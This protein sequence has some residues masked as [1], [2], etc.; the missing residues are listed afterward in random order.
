MTSIKDVHQ[1]LH[2]LA[3]QSKRVEEELERQI[4]DADRRTI[5]SRYALLK[6]GK[7]VS[8]IAD[9]AKVLERRLQVT[10]TTAERISESV[11]QLDEEIDRIER[12]SL[13]TSR[14]SDLRASLQSLSTAIAQQ[15]YVTATQHCV[16][17]LAI[18]TD[19]VHSEFA[20]LMVPSSE[21]PEPPPAVLLELR[22]KLLHIYTEKFEE[23]TAAKDTQ[24]ATKYFT[25]LPQIGWPQE[26]LQV[27]ANFARGM[28]RDKGQVITEGL[29]TGRGS[30]SLH[31]AA[32]LTYLF[33]NLASLIDQHQ[34]LVDLHY[35]AGSFFHGV[36]P[37][38]QQECDRL[39]KRICDTWFDERYVRRKV[40][41]A[42]AYEFTYVAGIGSAKR[43]Q[44]GTITAAGQRLASG[45]HVPGRPST[46]SITNNDEAGQVDTR[47]V[48]KIIGEL[49]AMASRWATYKRFLVIRLGDENDPSQSKIRAADN[50]EDEVKDYRKGSID[51]R[52][53]SVLLSQ[54]QSRIDGR[55]D[56]N[57]E[58]AGV[59]FS[60]ASILGKRVDE[61][62]NT[63]YIPL[64]CWFL[65][66]SLEKA[67]RMDTADLSVRPL[68]SSLL[69]DVFYLVRLV[70]AR[71][72]STCDL[73][74]LSTMC[75]NVRYIIDEDFMQPIIRTLDSTSR[76]SSVSMSVEGPRKDAASRELRQTFGVYLNVLSTSAEYMTRILNEVSSEQSLKQQFV[77]SEVDV[78]AST[79]Q[80]LSTIV[81][82]VRNAARTHMDLFF[83][84]LLRP[85]LRQLTSESLR[86]VNYVL[87]EQ[88]F[89]QAE[90]E[91]AS[92]GGSSLFVRRLLRGWETV[93]DGIG[94][95]T[96][97]TQDNW[98]ILLRLAIDAIVQTWETWA[99]NVEYSE[100]G[101]LRFDKDVRSVSTFLV[102][103]SNTGGLRDRFARL[104]HISYLVNLDDDVD[105]STAAAPTDVTSNADDDFAWR[106]SSAEIQQIRGRRVGW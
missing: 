48:D 52:R 63:A 17:A 26:G 59:Q 42:K 24:E 11:R 14:V 23:A 8:L 106:L 73:E 21:Q 10:G 25:M 29:G 89:A 60:R 12:A 87:N 65:R 83:S 85:K 1:A 16:R 39:G 46:P 35:G 95:R 62:L 31:H 80:G 84:T 103:Q 4:Q 38:L 5:S 88:D 40:E 30:G 56:S 78:A 76:S 64:E 22:Q 58:P 81:P 75:R 71:A 53:S 15:D 2:Q 67:H 36:M 9:E 3:Q 104:T 98:E 55:N 94:Y 27:Y 69:D 43:A 34:P 72:A 18:D 93:I 105:Q 49:S 57:V 51:D 54:Q 82:R 28:V 96:I 91:A 41:E 74:V 37:E 45:L 13:W 20:A 100:L 47:E 32:L 44:P 79:L 101:A 99:M 86:D 33:E 50:L 97:F 68:S 90:E 102:S 92:H 6:Q 77:A 66:C 61:M 7:Q 19:I 70:L